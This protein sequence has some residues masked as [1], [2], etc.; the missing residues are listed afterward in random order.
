MNS[1][2][3]GDMRSF[4]ATLLLVAPLLAGD[5]AGGS[6]PRATAIGESVDA[7]GTA[8]F[9]V[10]ARKLERIGW[11]FVEGEHT[12]YA[13]VG[14]DR[15]VRIQGGGG[16]IRGVDALTG[17]RKWLAG[18][19]PRFFNYSA[20]VLGRDGTAFGG[21]HSSV[22]AV[23]KNGKVRWTAALQAAWIHRPPALSPDGRTLFVG[24]DRLG[25]AALDASTGRVLWMRRDFASNW[26]TYVFETAGRLIAGFRDRAVCFDAR[27]GKERWRLDRPIE[28]LMVIGPRLV[29]S[30]ASTVTSIDLR[31]RETQW[32]VDLKATVH[33]IAYSDHARIVAALK[34]GRLVALRLDGTT[35]FDAAVSAHPLARPTATL[36]GDV[37][38]VDYDGALHLVDGSG[39]VEQSLAVGKPWRWRPML[40]PDGSVYVNTKNAVV[41]V[42]GAVRPPAV[43]LVATEMVVVA[44]D[45]VV[46]V[47][48][49]GKKLPDAAR[50]LLVEIHGAS[51][52]RVYADLR[53]G[54]WVVFHVV[55]N[56]MRWGGASYFGVHGSDPWG[57]QAFV[58]TTKGNWSHC[59]DPA[60][61]ARFIRERGFGADMLVVKPARPWAGA[62]GIWKDRLGHEFAGEPIWGGKSSTWIKLIVPARSLD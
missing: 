14:S 62:G 54:D 39:R 10:R 26:T 46:D 32:S 47:W 37:L 15:V 56:R 22:S 49:N 2:S 20:C 11:R 12:G 57:E 61:V 6:E 19:N 36:G 21:N 4:A 45:F 42:T 34:D 17:K 27:T 29:A 30:H 52:E 41:Q 58:S 18:G 33:G 9:P 13:C 3:N 53:P 48:V 38:V 25:I 60:R 31:T 8:Y 50:K 59:D 55:A 7:H 51:T 16:I 5:P 24:G 35:K 43:P 23:E 28:D 1:V 40:G 44:D